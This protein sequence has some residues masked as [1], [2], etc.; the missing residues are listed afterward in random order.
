MK[1]YGLILGVVLCLAF[2]LA[3]PDIGSAQQP[4]A[5]IRPEPESQRHANAGNGRR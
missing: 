5:K 2:V 1:R 4:P 3:L